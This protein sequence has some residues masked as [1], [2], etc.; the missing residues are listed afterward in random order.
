[1]EKP[2]TNVPTFSSFLRWTPNIDPKPEDL[3]NKDL[4]KAHVPL[5]I[6]FFLRSLELRVPVPRHACMSKATAS[7]LTVRGLTFTCP[8]A[9]RL[10]HMSGDGTIGLLQQSLR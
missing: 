1:M 3:F 5:T 2:S 7:T 4:K 9:C 10:L 6:Q 8:C